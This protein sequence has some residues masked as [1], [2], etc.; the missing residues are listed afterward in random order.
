MGEGADALKGGESLSSSSTTIYLKAIPLRKYEDIGLI[1][2]ELKAGN[3][4]ITN[5]SL[6]ARDNIDDLKKAIVT[7]SQFVTQIEGDI[8][9]LGEDRV[10]LTPK[11]VKI[12]RSDLERKA[13]ESNVV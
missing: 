10:V 12:W 3:I 13:A 8:A 1:Q 2:I 11:N 5:I 4:V 6:L 7:L 9:R